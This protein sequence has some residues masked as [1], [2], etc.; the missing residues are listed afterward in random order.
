M[1]YTITN[2]NPL[3]SAE[4]TNPDIVVCYDN[5]SDRFY[6]T[7]IATNTGYSVKRSELVGE[8]FKYTDAITQEI[9]R[10]CETTD[11]LDLTVVLTQKADNEVYM[12][13]MGN[14]DIF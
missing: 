7:F 12:I 5:K 13:W 11:E 14:C 4:L 9:L 6:V 2:N 3:I 10:A 1:A 8:S